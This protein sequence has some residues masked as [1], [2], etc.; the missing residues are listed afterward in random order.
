MLVLGL[1]NLSDPEE[2][3]GLALCVRRRKSLKRKAHS[4]LL[5]LVL[6]SR[7]LW[8][9]LRGPRQLV[10]E[11]KTKCWGEKKV[12]RKQG[13]AEE[14]CSKISKLSSVVVKNGIVAVPA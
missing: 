5:L 10:S 14:S 12:Q 7:P 8:S 9:N 1:N 4:S 6:Y 3:K 2:E 13:M 11:L